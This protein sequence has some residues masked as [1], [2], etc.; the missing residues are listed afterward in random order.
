MKFATATGIAVAAS[1]AAA[2]VY[3]N[4]ADTELY[5]V[6]PEIEREFMSYLSKH[7]KTYGTKE[8]YKFRLNVFSKKMKFIQ[9]YEETNAEGHDL[10]LNHMADWTSEEYNRVLGY[11]HYLNKNHMFGSNENTWAPKQHLLGRDGH[12]QQL[13]GQKPIGGGDH[14]WS[15][16]KN[17]RKGKHGKKHGKHQRGGKHRHLESSCDG[18][19][20]S[21]CHSD[22]TCSWCVSAAVKPA[23]RS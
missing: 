7:G 20:E 17:Y 12:D 10:A 21:D 22:S 18:K 4:N 15:W 14:D 3:Y 1:I 13:H 6:E 9:H 8:E 19:A 16:K 2:A 11:K 5:S 23:C